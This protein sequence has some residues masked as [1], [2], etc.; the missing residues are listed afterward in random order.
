MVGPELKMYQCGLPKEMAL[1]LFK[2]FV[3]KRL[4][5]TGAVGNIKAA[6]KSVERAKPEVWDALEV[7]IK[8]HPVLL[9]RAPTLHRLGIQAFEP[10][11]VEGRA[12][13][14]HP[15]VCTAYNADFD[16]DQMAV[17]VP[18]SAE[19]QAEARFLMLAANNLLKPSDGRPVTVPTQDMVLGSYYLTL[20]KDGEPGEGKVFRN[21]DEAMMA[22]DA[23]AISL[24][25]KIKVRRSVEFNGTTITGLVETTMGRMIFNRPIPQDLGY[26]DRSNPDEV[27]KF[28]I[29][30]LVGKKQLGKIIDRCIKVHGTEHTAEVLDNIKAQGYKYSTISGITV[31]VCDATIPKEKADMLKAADAEVDEIRAEYNEGFLSESE[32]YQAVLKVWDKCTRDVAAAL[33]KGLDRYNPIFMMADSGARG[34][35]S[36]LN[37]LA[38]M[39]GN[40]SNTSGKT[41]EIPIRANYREGLTILEYFISSRGARKGLADTAL[42]TAD[43]GYLTRRLVDVSQEVIILEDDCGTKEGLEVFEITA[44]PE[45]I[46]PLKERLVGRFLVED[47]CDEDGNVL[48]SKDKLMDDHDADLIVGR[49]V[50]RIKIRSVLNCRA[51]NGVCR[52]CYGASLANGKPVT[53]GE[54]VGIIAAQSIGEPGT[55]LTMRTFHT[56]GVASA[57][58]ITQGLPRVEELFEGRK[59]KHVAII[60]EI[61]GK[62][63][64]QEIKKNRHVVVTNDE[65][66]DSR[67]YLIPF[68]SRLTVKEG[69]YIKRGKR[70][71]EGS[72]NP[73]DVLAISGTQEVQDYL[74]QEVQRVYRM[75]GVDINDKHIE[76]IVRQMLRK[77]RIDDAGDTGL[78]VSSL[79]DKNEVLQ[80]NEDIR[81]R[82]ANGETTLREATYTPILL[83]ITKA[84]LATDSFLSAAS[85][86][87]T[88]RVLTDA[89][90][91]G[92][93]DNLIGLKENVIIGK[94]VPAGTGM[95]CYSDVEIQPE[96]GPEDDGPKEEKETL[97]NEELP[98]DTFEDEV[99]LEEEDLFN[100]EDG[101]EAE[102][103]VLEEPGA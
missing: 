44:G 30:F 10:V 54:A 3:M 89:A 22:Y 67:S 28:E 13:K 1:E 19:A 25:A 98:E 14:L 38:G 27:L 84:S 29:D 12:L 39:R 79:A 95:K 66:G 4:V 50:E 7:V 36:N 43:S 77:V 85:F 86:Q 92:K 103:D 35:I 6:R 87:E 68:G 23:K 102:D 80:A 16:G 60:N 31:A 71:T 88:T 49:G 47:F 61:D 51:K 63:T 52:K 8:N 70:I 62:V 40:I 91:K 101:E 45:S 82:I 41:I 15:L 9:N 58:D 26:V 21:M 96:G 24:H 94:L 46:E 17:H 97:L 56:G 59:P 11:L 90:I 75:Q 57:D 37:Q 72:V 32:R 81:E 99:D 2:P 100:E 42:R 69:E 34:S 65:T 93:V 76:I 33:Q 53:V 83:G 74:I 78:L 55:Q 5:E 20:D 73:H 48:V 18:L 64:F